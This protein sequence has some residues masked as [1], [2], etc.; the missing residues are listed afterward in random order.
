MSSDSDDY[1]F[2]YTSRKNFEDRRK[3]YVENEE[4]FRKDVLVN[5][6]KF[7][8][9]LEVRKLLSEGC[10][11]KS[12]IVKKERKEAN[13]EIK[14]RFR[15]YLCIHGPSRSSTSTGQRNV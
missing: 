12:C 2:T 7:H 13:S 3:L 4:K 10:Q 9:D 8:S 5:N 1:E 15:R 6:R 11:A 14:Y